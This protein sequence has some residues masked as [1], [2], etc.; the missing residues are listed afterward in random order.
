MAV[1]GKFKAIPPSV[2]GENLRNDLQM[3]HKATLMDSA[4]FCFIYEPQ[5]LILHTSSHLKK[6]SMFFKC[7]LGHTDMQRPFPKMLLMYCR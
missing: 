1:G 3:I 5:L 4:L 6:R 2:V 7:I